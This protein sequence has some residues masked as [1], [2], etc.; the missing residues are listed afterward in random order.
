MPISLELRV[1]SLRG[2]LHLQIKPPPSDQ[3]WIG[4]TSMPKI[5]LNFSSSIGDHKIV[6]TH[7]AMLINNRFKVTDYLLVS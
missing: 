5:E 4:F 1:A 2:T 6:S 3:I 7:V